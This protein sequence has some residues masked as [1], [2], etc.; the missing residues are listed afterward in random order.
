[1]K[2]KMRRVFDIVLPAFVILVFATALFFC[3]YLLSESASYFDNEAKDIAQRYA[4]QATESVQN[5]IGSSFSEV[6]SIASEVASVSGFE[7]MDAFG[8]SKV[9][10]YSFTS[11]QFLK[12]G[13]PEYRYGDSVGSAS[14]VQVQNLVSQGKFGA[15]EIYNDPAL[16]VPCVAV[17]CP[18]ASGVETDGVI[19][20]YP[21]SALFDGTDNLHE[22]TEY[23]FFSSV[24]GGI[25]ESK[26]SD[27]MKTDVSHNVFTYLYNLTE[28]RSETEPIENQVEN[29]MSGAFFVHID[30]EKY[31]AVCTPVRSF[32]GNCFVLQLYAAD[33]ILHGE[34]RL[35]DKVLGVSVF[36]AVFSVIVLC[37][38][39][40]TARA[41]RK[42]LM[43]ETDVDPILGCNTY[44]KFLVDAGEIL[45]QNRFSKY[46]VIYLDIYKFHY[47][48]EN[49]GN[50]AAENIVKFLSTFFRQMTD[51]NE[52]YGHIV[53]DSFALLLHYT[54]MAELGERIKLMG[55]LVS[56]Y[57]AEN[58]L[59]MD[60]KLSVGVFPVKGERRKDVRNM[61]DCAKIALQAN[62][63]QPGNP[64]TVYDSAISTAYLHEAELEAKM[65][66]ALKN[67]D[68]KLFFQPKY[69]IKNDRI[70]S[71]EV[72]VRWYDT[73]LKSYIAP[74]S[75]IRLFEANGF[76]SELDHY[77]FEETCRFLND[78]TT[79]GEKIVPLSVNVSRATAIK[80]DFLKFYIEKKKEYGVAD[81]FITLEFT[82][83]FAADS[84]DLFATLLTSLENNGFKCAIDDFG[85]G[86]SSLIAVK[87]LPVN[88]LKFDRALLKQ[89]TD[90]KKDNALL[91]LLID[92]SKELGMTVT[93]EGVETREDMERMRALGCDIIQGYYYSKPM[94]IID[95][96]DFMQED[97]SLAGI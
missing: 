97:T 9:R 60:I 16:G 89:N 59:G 63:K 80:P 53:E 22:L 90:A 77:V 2:T 72:L 6:K 58:N 68:F 75:F 81:G 29:K 30:G 52:S 83:S 33:K 32:S 66:N 91:K 25:I 36:L 54:D 27:G 5:E 95:F 51:R 57:N 15:S 37:V 74:D 17:Y 64:Y 93:Q 3:F 87:E 79:R 13:V 7:E 46:A 24:D 45:E 47:Y 88:E 92:V 11:L 19:V 39:S 61:L 94:H 14:S 48:K 42:K 18:V 50:S 21:L 40:I 96:I 1:M 34:Y 71:A 44:N 28:N 10:Q 20:Y 56:N 62:R 84:Y 85:M 49:L 82:E 65:K 43:S 31:V 4:L 23:Y 70:D 69:S 26:I 38:S 55:A 86:N 12:D 8:E 78:F 76:V 67:R 73:K 41:D 35:Y